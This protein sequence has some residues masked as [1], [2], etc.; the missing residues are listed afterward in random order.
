[1]MTRI[2]TSKRD[3]WLVS[4]L[5]GSAVLPLVAGLLIV[6]SDAK[7]G[8]YLITI[9]IVTFVL[10]LAAT[11]PLYYELRER[12][13]VI[14]SGLFRWRI[15][16]ASI[17]EVRP[18][19]SIMSAPALSLDRLIIRFRNESGRSR[20]AMIS[21]RDREGFVREIEERTPGMLRVGEGLVRTGR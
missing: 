16:L 4:V 12:A 5:W 17:D 9:S 3:A 11:F 13:L 18:T 19:R 20:F 15:P 21:P 1:M 2:F 7:A 14:R 10:L 6:W 8:S